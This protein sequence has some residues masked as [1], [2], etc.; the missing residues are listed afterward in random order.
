MGRK[1]AAAS[2]LAVVGVW[3][4]LPAVAEAAAAKP[5]LSFAPQAGDSADYGQVF[6]GDDS[7]SQTFILTNDGGRAT[8]RL[9]VSLN[10]SSAFSKTADTCSGRG[11]KPSVSCSVTVKYAPVAAGHDSTS[12]LAVNLAQYNMCKFDHQAVTGTPLAVG[13]SC[14]VTVSLMGGCGEV[15]LQNQM[16]YEYFTDAAQTTRT[17]AVATAN[18]FL[19]PCLP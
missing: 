1:L 13:A 2:A 12:V 18:G 9:T 7:K 17:F 8:S 6:V 4:M 3:A 19:P 14:F 16:A 11:L 10:G 15:V 5:H